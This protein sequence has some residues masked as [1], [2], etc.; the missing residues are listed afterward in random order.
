MGEIQLTY[1]SKPAKAFNGQLADMNP[2]EIVSKAAEGEIGFGLAVEIG[3][4]DNQVAVASGGAFFGMSVR[5][6]KGNDDL[7]DAVYADEDAVRTLR[8][9]Y[10][11]AEVVGS[12][13][14]GAALS[15][16]VATG[17]LSTTVQN[18]TTHIT[19]RCTL[20]ETTTAT[21][22]ALVRVATP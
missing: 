8:G 19:T 15:Y 2:K 9:G 14:L 13:S 7:T 21:G 6:N 1:D 4:G 16:E 12:G 11:Y 17:K 10:I 5:V 3:S 18:G 20:E 22:T